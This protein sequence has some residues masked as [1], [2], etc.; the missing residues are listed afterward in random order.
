MTGE[1]Y[2]QKGESMERGK[3]FFHYLMPDEEIRCE[4]DGERVDSQPRFKLC[5]IGETERIE[6]RELTTDELT[7]L[8]ERIN[9]VLASV[10]KQEV[11]ANGAG[12]VQ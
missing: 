2:L 10:P 12:T 1:I 8:R 11:A 5:I 3:L 9:E 6:I 4:W 7:A